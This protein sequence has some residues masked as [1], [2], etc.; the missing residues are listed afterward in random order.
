MDKRLPA[1]ALSSCLARLERYKQIMQI[2]IANSGSTTHS[3]WVAMVFTS[4]LQAGCHGHTT[5]CQDC[6][7]PMTVLIVENNIMWTWT[8]LTKKQYNVIWCVARPHQDAHRDVWKQPKMLL[9]FQIVLAPSTIFLFMLKFI[10]L[11]HFQAHSARSPSCYLTS[12]IAMEVNFMKSWKEES[13]LSVLFRDLIT[14]RRMNVKNI[15]W[16]SDWWT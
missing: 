6:Y 3:C 10:V 11:F 14:E 9:S 1:I 13:L 16:C 2:K 12:C 5:L 4:S 8:E 7:W 15:C